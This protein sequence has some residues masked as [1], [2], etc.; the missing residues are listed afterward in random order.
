L[1]ANTDD[2]LLDLSGADWDDLRL[3]RV[4]LEQG[5]LRA[6][7]KQEGVVVNTVRGRLTRLEEAMA[8]PLL[9]RTTQGVSLTEAG[10]QLAE[11]IAE[12]SEA[13]F[14]ARAGRSTDVLVCP[15]ELTIA[16]SEGLGTLWLTP[17]LAKLR[18]EIPDLTIGLLCDYNLARDRTSE[19]DIWLTFEQP[20]RQDLIVSKL[21]T[22]HFLPFASPAYVQQNGLPKTVD[23]LKTHRIVEHCGA[24][25]RSELLDYLIGSDRPNGLLSLRTNSSLAQLWAVAEGEGIGGLPTFVREL[26]RAVVP[27]PPVLQIRRELRLVYRADGRHSPAVQAAVRWLRSIFDPI[28]HPCFRDTFVHPDDFRVLQTGGVLRLFASMFDEFGSNQ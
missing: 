11:T 6:A 1:D 12:M 18:T 17:R 22:L 9:R 8:R 16:C 24:G 15:G 5:S 4:I 25:V 2:E 23:D 20:T 14:R 28:Q 7:A 27:V 26:T 13:T 3:F 21:A 19:A 10:G